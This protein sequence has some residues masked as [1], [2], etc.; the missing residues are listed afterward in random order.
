MMKAILLMHQS[1][2][3]LMQIEDYLKLIHQSVYGPAHISH[4][5]NRDQLLAYLHHEMNLSVD[6]PSTS[7]IEPIGNHYFRVSIQPVKKRWMTDSVLI[8][9]FFQSMID[10]LFEDVNDMMKHHL[11]ELK[12]LIEKGI[13]LLDQV[14]SMETII[15]YQ[16]QGYQAIHHSDIYRK[17][18]HPHYRVIHQKHMKTII[19]QIER[20]TIQ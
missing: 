19:E 15:N 6:D 11:E 20:K 13:I 1:K 18:Y 16:N 14:K 2:Y 9:A 4:Q 8:D 5:P 3:P 17:T 7:W 10:P 12:M